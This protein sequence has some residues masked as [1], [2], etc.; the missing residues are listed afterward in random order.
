MSNKTYQLSVQR[1]ERGYSA[2]H[3][4]KSTDAHLQHAKKKYVWERWRRL[5]QVNLFSTPWLAGKL[6]VESKWEMEVR[7]SEGEEACYISKEGIQWIEGWCFC[8]C[9][10]SILILWLHLQPRGK[11]RD[12]ISIHHSGGVLAHRVV[13]LWTI[14]RL[15]W[16]RGQWRFEH[17]KES[18]IYVVNCAWT[19]M[20]SLSM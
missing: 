8:C 13:R 10:E 17:L 12:L 11:R 16:R 18:V 6:I 1:Q 14:S 20:Q 7:R 5:S 4:N 15:K 19:T 9:G 3:K 2:E